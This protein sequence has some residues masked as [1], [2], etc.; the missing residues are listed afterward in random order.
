MDDRTEIVQVPSSPPGARNVSPPSSTT[1]TQRWGPPRPQGIDCIIYK[2]SIL[3]R[4]CRLEW[5]EGC[6]VKFRLARLKSDRDKM[7]TVGVTE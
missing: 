5:R 6:V 1:S 7:S 4:E 3:T 2:S